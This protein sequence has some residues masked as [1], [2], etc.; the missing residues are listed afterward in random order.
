MIA[1]DTKKLPLVEK[2]DIELALKKATPFSTALDLTTSLTDFQEL[3][4]RKL[5]VKRTYGRQKKSGWRMDAPMPSRT[6]PESMTSP[7]KRPKEVELDDDDPDETMFQPPFSLGSIKKSK[8]ARFI[9]SDATPSS[10]LDRQPSTSFMDRFRRSSMSGSSRPTA[11]TPISEEQVSRRWSSLSFTSSVMNAASSAS[12]ALFGFDNSTREGIKNL[13]N[14]CYINATL[15]ALFH[16]PTLKHDLLRN[17]FKQCPLG[18]GTVYRA[19]I[20]I[21]AEKDEAKVVDPAQFKQVIGE[22]SAQFATHDQQDADEFLRFILD[23]MEMELEPF[24][25]PATDE[26][27]SDENVDPSVNTNEVAGGNH[28][29]ANPVPV[30]FQFEIEHWVECA[31]CSHQSKNVEIY[32]DLPLFLPE[33]SS[34]STDAT[35]ATAT[36]LDLADLMR[37]YFAQHQ[38]SYACEKC[39]STKANVTTRIRQ[40]PRTLVVQLKRFTVNHGSGRAYKRQDA[41]TFSHELDVKSCC[42]DTVQAPPDLPEESEMEV[43]DLTQDEP[44][45]STSDKKKPAPS[46]KYRLQAVISHMGEAST[47]GHYICDVHDAKKKQWKCYNDTRMDLVGD[48]AEVCKKRQKSA[49]LLFYVH[50]Q[51]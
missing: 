22:A 30:N 13:G 28:R 34:P 29:P 38:V 33:T 5:E 16:L 8:Q 24:C 47:S 27:T 2:K 46:Q 48:A 31:E 3:E 23:R 45:T 20:D 50:D 4:Q 41:I 42:S 10:T 49:Y 15:Q 14:T 44:I 39:P 26:D 17:T 19:F 25:R 12:S 51:Q 9:L 7:L 36:K 37:Q 35:T 40:L 11:S 21:L 6:L 32:R 43:I 1:I 18:E